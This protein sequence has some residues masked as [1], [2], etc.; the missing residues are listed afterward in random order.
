MKL[1]KDYKKFVK[2]LLKYADS[3]QSSPC[4][5]QSIQIP[6]I[7]KGWTALEFDKIHFG[8]GKGCCL[9]LP[10][11]GY[12]VNIDYCNSIN[13]KF[14]SSMKTTIRIWLSIL[15]PLFLFGLGLFLNKI[16]NN[17]NQH[18]NSE[19]PQFHNQNPPVK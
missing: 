17:T 7:F 2:S 13:D 3:C 18:N 16:N 15:V 1:N 14:K 5:F 11:T 12:K 6:E 10:P 19:K 8:I 4:Y 9:Y